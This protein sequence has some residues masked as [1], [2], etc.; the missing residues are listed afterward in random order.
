MRIQFRNAGIHTGRIRCF[1]SIDTGHGKLTWLICRNG[2]VEL[3]GEF[4]GILDLCRPAERSY[5][6]AGIEIHHAWV[7][8]RYKERVPGLSEC[9]R[10]FLP[11]EFYIAVAQAQ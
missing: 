5:G 4:C 11:I 3:V 10:M 2:S 6:D 7:A 8:F 9:K 1:G